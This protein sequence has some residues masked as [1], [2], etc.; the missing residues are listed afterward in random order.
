M[1]LLC[2]STTA[3]PGANVPPY[4]WTPKEG[5]LLYPY[6]KQFSFEESFDAA[7]WSN[8]ADEWVI[9]PIVGSIMYMVLLI[10]GREYMKDKDPAVARWVIVA[11]NLFL[12]LFSIL[13]MWRMMPFIVG[14]LQQPRGV[15]ILMCA[16][17]IPRC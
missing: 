8:W 15:H 9:V 4:S 10:N 17:S 1:Y 11:W 7:A 3:A 13:G 2:L 5:D 6:L 14:H 16:E 12:S